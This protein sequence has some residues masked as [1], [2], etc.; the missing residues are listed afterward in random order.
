MTMNNWTTWD[1][2]HK[3]DDFT[4]LGINKGTKI[5]DVPKHKY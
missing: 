3:V 2:C 1:A 5:I 4:T